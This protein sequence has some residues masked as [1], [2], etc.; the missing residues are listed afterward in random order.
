MLNLL[1]AYNKYTPITVIYYIIYTHYT[2]IIVP[3]SNKKLLIILQ[4]II[5]LF[6]INM[7]F[8]PF[9]F[10]SYL[11]FNKIKVWTLIPNSIF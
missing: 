10:I 5:I 3:Y 8:Y 11:Q 7:L 9:S 6:I 2:H 1:N 4:D